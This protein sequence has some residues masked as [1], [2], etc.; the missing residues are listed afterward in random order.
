MTE[1]ENCYLR[2][3]DELVEILKSENSP[4]NKT[5]KAGEK[6]NFKFRIGWNWAFWMNSAKIALDG[7]PEVFEV[8][9]DKGKYYFTNDPKKL[10]G[11]MDYIDELSGSPTHEKYIERAEK[12]DYSD[13]YGQKWKVVYHDEP[14]LDDYQLDDFDVNYNI[15]FSSI[16]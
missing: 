15:S 10:M 9:S 6:V 11:T 1:C 12:N 2:N 8:R 4:L 16:S 13:I 3:I 14:S 5:F 7:D